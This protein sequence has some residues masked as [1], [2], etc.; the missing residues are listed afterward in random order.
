MITQDNL[1]RNGYSFNYHLYHKCTFNYNLTLFYILN[2]IHTFQTELENL[3]IL[4]WPQGLTEVV[5]LLPNKDYKSGLTENSQSQQW[6]PK[7]LGRLCLLTS[8]KQCSFK[9]V[10]TLVLSSLEDLVASFRG[11]A[12]CSLAS[13]KSSFTIFPVGGWTICNP[14]YLWSPE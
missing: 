8:Q 3:E 9:T 5:Q 14:S 1:R 2:Q 13:L 12:P 6:V 4:K 10:L 7:W 11:T